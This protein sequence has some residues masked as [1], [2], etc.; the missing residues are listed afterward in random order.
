MGCIYTA[1][2][3]LRDPLSA[4]H[5]ARLEPLVRLVR[6]VRQV[7]VEPTDQLIAI[8]FDDGLVGL[9]ELVRALE[10]EGVGVEGVAQRRQP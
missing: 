1:I 3:H 8:E 9:A 2:I 10:D 6:G 5:Q 4:E 7:S